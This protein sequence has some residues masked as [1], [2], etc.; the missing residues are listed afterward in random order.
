MVG[1]A[2]AEPREPA[3]GRA[4]EAGS[5]EGRGPLADDTSPAGWPSPGRRLSSSVPL[6]RRAVRPYTVGII[7][8]RTARAAV[9]LPARVTQLMCKDH[10]LTRPFS[11]HDGP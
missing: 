4:G 11:D 2:G 3:G 6:A 8:Y 10:R 9:I 7:S 5:D 1:L